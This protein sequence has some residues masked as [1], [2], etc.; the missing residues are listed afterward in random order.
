MSLEPIYRSQFYKYSIHDTVD[1]PLAIVTAGYLH[2]SKFEISAFADRKDGL[3]N[4]QILY[5]K[6]GTGIFQLDGKEVELNGGRVLIFREGEPEVYRYISEKTDTFWVHFGGYDAAKLLDSYGLTERTIPISNGSEIEKLICEIT[7]EVTHRKQ[8]FEEAA[9]SKLK[10]LL[11]EISR[12]D[13]IKNYDWATAAISSI[14]DEIRFNY[15]ENLTNSEYAERCGMSLP[16][17]LKNFKKVS[18][19]TPQEYKTAQ[20]ISVAQNMLIT[21]DY[22]I[23]YIAQIT[24]FS[25]PL[26]FSRCFKKKTGISPENYRKSNKHQ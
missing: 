7:E 2:H 25:D 19:T 5:F 8:H 16:Y 20:R 1:E 4:C 11:I 10:L 14:M 6:R 17:F 13:N 3:P 22:K 21:T 12:I 15:F 18:G 24:G 9:I 23:N 26:Y